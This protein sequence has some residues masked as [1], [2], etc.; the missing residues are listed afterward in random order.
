MRKRCGK[1]FSWQAPDIMALQNS[2]PFQRFGRYFC[3]ALELRASFYS[4]VFKRGELS[5]NLALDG[6]KIWMKADG[7]TS[8][9]GGQ[10]TL[11]RK[12]TSHFFSTFFTETDFQHSK[13]VESC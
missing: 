11:F 13:R 5:Q 2:Q 3:K 4:E 1:P 6:C 9:S 12:R 8:E 10:Q 7:E